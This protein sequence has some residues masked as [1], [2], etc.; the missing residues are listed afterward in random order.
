MIK[1]FYLSHGAPPMLEEEI[2]FVQ[3]LH[4]LRKQLIDD[5]IDLIIVAS[6]HWITHNQLL[7]HTAD[8]PNCIQDYYGFPDRF[9]DYTYQVS[10]APEFAR[11]LIKAG[12]A[13]NIP[14]E[15]TTSW[16]LDHGAWVP[17]HIMFPEKQIPVLPISSG[18]GISAQQHYRWGEIIRETAQAEQYDV[19]FLGTGSTVHRLDQ[20]RWQQDNT[21]MFPPGKSFD[22]KLIQLLI[23]NSISEVLHIE[24]TYPDL[25]QNA[26]PEGD[27]K[28]LYIALGVAGSDANPTVLSHQG[29]HYGV[30]LLAVEL[31]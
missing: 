4:Q 14:V 27:L 10:G 1:S 18:D 12:K 24:K 25:Y 5:S 15:D 11:A 8:Q 22:E 31:A 3:Q 17:L 16:G 6:P 30:S 29:W 13:A 20:I 19:L 9:Y 21:K 23:D 26:A 2:P 28:S 7:V